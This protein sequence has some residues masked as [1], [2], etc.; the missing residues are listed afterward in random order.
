MLDGE[1]I[2]NGKKFSNGCRFPGDPQGPSYEV[3]NCRCTLVAYMPDV[4]AGDALH[5]DRYGVLP[6]MTYAQ[7][8]A[9]KR[10]AEAKP[11]S[12]I[13]TKEVRDWRESLQKQ[14]NLAI[15]KKKIDS[16]ALS[17][18]ISVQ[19]QKHIE[20]TPQFKLYLAGRIAK[21]EHSQRILTISIEEA[22]ELVNRYSCTGT[23]DTAKRGKMR[24]VDFTTTEIIV[25]KYFENDDFRKTARIAIHYSKKGAHIVPVKEK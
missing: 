17:A 14:E 6:N 23:A 15:F 10:G 19:Q 18:E 11:I 25:V 20:G 12:P 16:G 5:R 7:R 8:E 1:H 2:D 21:G 13:R 9:S 3:Y 24:T 22:Q 4:N